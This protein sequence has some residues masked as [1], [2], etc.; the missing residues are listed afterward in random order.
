MVQALAASE[1]SE[2]PKGRRV[3]ALVVALVGVAAYAASLGYDFVWDDTLLI[4]QSVRLHQ[5]G[6]LPRLLL[7][8]F[9]SEVGEASHYYRPLITLSFFLDLK[10]WGLHP[11]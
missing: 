9:W 10:V 4:Q 6:E 3:A 2:T 11:F 8:Q 5:W 1:R 7:S